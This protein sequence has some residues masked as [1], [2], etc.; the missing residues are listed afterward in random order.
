MKSGS[1]GIN[2]VIGI[3]MLI[4]ARK[5]DRLHN[6]LKSTLIGSQEEKDYQNTE[7][8]RSAENA[9][10]TF[11][12]EQSEVNSHLYLLGFQKPVLSHCS[13]PFLEVINIRADTCK[14]IP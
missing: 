10:M 12:L 7:T 1:G 13:S 3:N 6:W 9:L 8:L 14:E 4:G 5:E 11:E 2:G